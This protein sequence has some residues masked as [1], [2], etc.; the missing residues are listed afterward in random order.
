MS[1]YSRERTPE[2]DGTEFVLFDMKFCAYAAVNKFGDALKPGFESKL[3]NREDA[4]LDET[5]APELARDT[6]RSMNARAVQALIMASKNDNLMNLIKKN[7]KADPAW[8]GAKAWKIW[9]ELQ[10]EYQPDDDV[11]EAELE[12]EILGLKFKKGENPK[13]IRKATS[14]LEVKYNTAIGESKKRAIVIRLC[15]KEYGNMIAM[16]D[17]LHKASGQPRV[18]TSDEL[19]EELF[20]QWRLT[21]GKT[22]VKGSDNDDF[23]TE[24]AL[25]NVPTKSP[26]TCYNCGKPGHKANVCRAPKKDGA[27]RGGRGGR[28]GGGRG[29][30]G[31][32][33]KKECNHCG[34]VGHIEAEC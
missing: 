15:K 28:G 7:M 17:M 24:T 4:V 10:V 13:N 16:T 5:K 31:R 9:D 22:S 21:G 33:S 14:S 19:V 30:G 27:G 23:A 32:H 1:T 11:A 18:A 2:F 34:K 25:N 12:E 8:P 26:I 20:K 3:P 6:A 29:N